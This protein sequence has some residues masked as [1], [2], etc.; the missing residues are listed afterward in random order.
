MCGNNNY[1][2][3]NRKFKAILFFLLLGN[4]NS[5]MLCIEVGMSTWPSSQMFL[6]LLP[7]VVLMTPSECRSGQN[8]KSVRMFKKG[9]PSRFMLFFYVI[10]CHSK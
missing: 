7:T 9:M 3:K 10:Q 6:A 4:Y 5:A 2:K 8:S 1:K